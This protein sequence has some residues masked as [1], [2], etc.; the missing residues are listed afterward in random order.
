M[1]RNAGLILATIGALALAMGC[2]DDDPKKKATGGGGVQLDG[3][4]GVTLDQGGGGT[5]DTGGGGNQDTGGGTGKNCAGISSCAGSCSDAA[6]LQKCISQGTADGQ[7][8]FNSLYA[9]IQKVAAG[10]CKSK[11]ATPS[12]KTCT[13]CI[14]AACKA[15]YTACGSGGSTGTA[16][17]GDACGQT[18]GGCKSGLTCAITQKGAS[19]GFCSQKCTNSGK[20][21][22][23][24]PSG[25]EAYCLLSDG[26]GT[27]YCVFLCK[28]KTSSGSKTVPC[29]TQLT[30]GTTENPAGSGQYS[31]VPK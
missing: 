7:K 2:G 26:K 10:S 11:C 20:A 25:T 8:K 21:C 18:T 9:C 27:N 4:G 19:K 22:T 14:Q 24:A 1:F 16:G 17:F 30:C 28:Y 3:G 29:P 6:C 15:E 23:G 13:D 5:Q 31:C 12:S